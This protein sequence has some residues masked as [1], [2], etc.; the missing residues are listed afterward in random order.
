M[1]AAPQALVASFCRSMEQ[2][3]PVARRLQI[4]FPY[5]LLDLDQVF[6]VIHVLTRISSN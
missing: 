4:A 6:F 5:E 2:L 1:T 3:G